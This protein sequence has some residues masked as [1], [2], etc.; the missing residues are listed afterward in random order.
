M[1]LLTVV[2]L[3]QTAVTDALA[4]AQA[5]VAF[6]NWTFLVGQSWHGLRVVSALVFGAISIATVVIWIVRVCRRL[7]DFLQVVS[8]P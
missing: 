6:N 3:R 5:P 2:T 1:S 7:R 4:T 8:D